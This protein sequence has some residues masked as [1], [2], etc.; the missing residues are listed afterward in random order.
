MKNIFPT[1]EEI[2]QGYCVYLLHN[3]KGLDNCGNP[4]YSEKLDMEVAKIEADTA[5]YAGQKNAAIA[6]QGLA[7]TNGWTV[8]TYK[9]PDGASINKLLKSDGE[10][11]TQAELEIDVKNY[12]EKLKNDKWDGKLP[13]YYLGSDGSVTTVIPTPGN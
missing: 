10:V 4:K 1:F 12:L 8:V 11:V 13:I 2:D 9:T 6:L 3:Y 7:S 5:E